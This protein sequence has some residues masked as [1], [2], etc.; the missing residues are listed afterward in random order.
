MTSA[1]PACTGKRRNM[2]RNISGA[3]ARTQP[4]GKIE[5]AV[6]IGA[7]PTTC[8]AG[9]LP[10]PPDLDEIMFAGF[11]RRDPVEMVRAKR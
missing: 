2:A 6:A 5:V 4:D 10:I 7:D 3:R 11:L 8:L 1:R 9:I